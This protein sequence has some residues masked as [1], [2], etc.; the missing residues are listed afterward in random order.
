MSFTSAQITNLNNAMSANQDVEL[1]TLLSL[2]PNNVVASGSFA[3]TAATD[4]I[5]TGLLTIK[6]VTASLSGSPVPTHFSVGVTTGSVAGTIVLSYWKPTS[7]S[8][9]AMISASA[10]PWVNVNWVATGTML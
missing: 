3:P 5:V 2:I 4:T 9:V 6:S 7:A 8:N 10:A 1:G